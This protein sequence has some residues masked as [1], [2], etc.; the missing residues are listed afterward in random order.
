MQFIHLRAC[1]APACALLL[2]SFVPAL[3][4]QGVF[5]Q[6]KA[7]NTNSLAP[8]VTS[9]QQIVDKMLEAAE[10]KP[11]ELVYDLGSGDG[12]VV[13]TAVQKFN[14]NAVGVELDEKLAKATTEKIQKLGLQNRAKVIQGNMLEVDIS[15]ADVV[16]M[17]LT[18]ESNDILRPALEKQLRPGTRVVSHDFQVRGWTPVRV[19]S[20]QAHN[21][22]HQIY[23]YQIPK[24]K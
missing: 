8:Y 16:V 20:A 7:K 17:Y 12:R 22:N 9:P 19:A 15:P 18:T 2:V 1:A 13:L 14:A 5:A 3:S 4:A 24:K 21:R 23:I 11:G 6:S 10:L